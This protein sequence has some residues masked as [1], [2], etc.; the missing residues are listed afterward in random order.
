MQFISSELNRKLRGDQFMTNQPYFKKKGLTIKDLVITGIFSAIYLVFTFLGGILFA[1]NPVL[2]F[3]TPIGMA[4]LCGPVFLLLVAKVPK[5]GPVTILGII[6][7]IILFATGMHWAFGLGFMIMGVLAD[8]VLIL[9]KHKSPAVSII[10]YMV[11]SLG[12][13]GTYAIFFMD[14]AS[15]SETMIRYGTPESYTET[16]ANSVFTGLLP[17]IIVG[18]LL[19]ALV[20]GLIGRKMLKKQFEKAGITA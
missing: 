3:Y 8:I 9:G 13:I 7:G 2:T 17:V 18:T 19:A 15:W 4:L 10:A 16:M 12:S 11:Y 14:P 1:P 6:I 20:S 5:Y